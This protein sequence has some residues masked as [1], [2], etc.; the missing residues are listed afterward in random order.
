MSY[1]LPKHL[2][3]YTWLNFGIPLPED[4]EVPVNLLTP[5]IAAKVA[6]RI[7][8]LQARA[9]GPCRDCKWWGEP[10]RDLRFE[11][12]E[13]TDPTQELKGY[14]VETGRRYCERC[15]EEG[16]LF[17]PDI[18]EGMSYEVDKLGLPTRPKFGCVQFE[19]R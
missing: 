12:K 13:K 5:E 3:F 19:A 4:A 6:E 1:S 10:E 11:Q 2:A 18:R 15:Y 16:A 9:C 14:W 7:R 8:E 17:E